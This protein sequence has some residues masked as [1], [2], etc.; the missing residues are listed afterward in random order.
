METAFGFFY[1]DI[2]GNTLI[3]GWKIIEMVILLVFALPLLL[4][5][6]I[7]ELVLMVRIYK[8]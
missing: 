1:F 6:Y 7:R 4:I 3:Y 8:Y 2:L 5:E